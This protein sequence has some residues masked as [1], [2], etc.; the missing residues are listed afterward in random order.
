MENFRDVCPYC[1]P[2]DHFKIAHDSPH[3]DIIEVQLRMYQK[4]W[5]KVKGVTLTKNR[6][7]TA[8]ARGDYWIITLTSENH[9]A[10]VFKGL[11]VEVL[12]RVYDFPM[13]AFRPL[14]GC[15]RINNMDVTFEACRVIS[16][17]S[18]EI[19]V[20][21][22][23][24]WERIFSICHDLYHDNGLPDLKV[25]KAAL[26]LFKYADARGDKKRFSLLSLTRAAQELQRDSRPNP[27]RITLEILAAHINCSVKGLQRWLEI[28]EITFDEVCDDARRMTEVMAKHVWK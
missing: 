3:G 19:R 24:G 7:V 16:E 17:N 21:W 2:V 13:P 23:K 4:N 10:P 12:G 18:S 20:H 15:A 14:F 26:E 9:L 6:S 11:T 5:R 27:P 8:E 1:S 28:E 25:I 22:H